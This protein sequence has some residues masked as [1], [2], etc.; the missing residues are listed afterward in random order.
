MANFGGDN[1]DNRQMSVIILFA[2]V[3]VIYI[4]A[5]DTR[6]FNQLFPTEFIEQYMNLSPIDWKG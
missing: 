3:C 6:W 5:G 2:C 4:H 1:P